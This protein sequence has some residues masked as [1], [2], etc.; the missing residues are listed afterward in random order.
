MK[1]KVLRSKTNDRGR[2]INSIIMHNDTV[3]T[4]KDPEEET[5]SDDDQVTLNE[6]NQVKNKSV[7]GQQRAYTQM[8]GGPPS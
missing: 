4:K 7:G 3:S 8:T 2:D 5:T 1:V 6:S